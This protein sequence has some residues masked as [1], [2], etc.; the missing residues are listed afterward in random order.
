MIKITAISNI[1]L[2]QHL[3]CSLSKQASQT[4]YV[5]ITDVRYVLKKRFG[6]GSYGEVWLAFH[7]NCHSDS[8]TSS[9]SEI[10]KNVSG[11]TM[12]EDLHTKS[13]HNSSSAHDCH[14]GSSDDSLFILKRIMV[15]YLID[16][17]FHAL[18]HI[19]LF[20]FPI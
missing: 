7:W 15:N 12:H 16:G 4:L 10:N 17:F 20:F 9:K 2:I 14:S 19:I 3:F 1:I 11:H 18:N 5:L 8:K 13:S 6:R